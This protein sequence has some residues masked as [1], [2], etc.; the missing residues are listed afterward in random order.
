M[1]DRTLL[2]DNWE[3]LLL[4]VESA[5]EALPAPGAPWKAVD[6]PHDWLI[7]RVNDL[8]AD[9][10]GWYRRPLSAAELN[11]RGAEGCRTFLRFDGVYMDCAVF[12]NGR[13]VFEWK[14][15]YTAFEFEIT[16]ALRQGAGGGFDDAE[17]L[18]R[19]NNFV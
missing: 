8:Y 3:F 2:Y 12:V 7:E 14:Y 16:D 17:I 18:V 19:R 5:S 4:P 1:A 15:G 10:I 11:A 9:G 6:L 13:R